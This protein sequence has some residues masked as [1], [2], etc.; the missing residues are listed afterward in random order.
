MSTKFTPKITFKVDAGEA[1]AAVVEELISQ[2]K[3]EP[4]DNQ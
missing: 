4:T 2:V 3:N 1:R